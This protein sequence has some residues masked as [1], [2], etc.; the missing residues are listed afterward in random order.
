M[1]VFLGLNGWDF[2]TDEADVTTTI[3]ALAAGEVE[4]AELAEWIRGKLVRRD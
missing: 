3:T 4:E 2:I 1:A